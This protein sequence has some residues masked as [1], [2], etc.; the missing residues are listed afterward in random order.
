MGVTKQRTSVLQAK[1]KRIKQVIKNN[2]DITPSQLRARF[3]V[4]YVKL[5]KLR[6][7]VE[8]ANKTS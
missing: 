5:A 2:P 6:Q 4:G 7:E 3:S 8:N 1:Y